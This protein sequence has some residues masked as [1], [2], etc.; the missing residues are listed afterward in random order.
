MSDKDYAWNDISHGGEVLS[1]II[2]P[3]QSSH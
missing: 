1:L 3:S 2:C